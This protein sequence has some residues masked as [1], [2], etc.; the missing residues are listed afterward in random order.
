MVIVSFVRERTTNVL[1]LVFVFAGLKSLTPS[2]LAMC[3]ILI[4]KV[5]L[6]TLRS[7]RSHMNQ[8]SY[9]VILPYKKKPL[10]SQFFAEAKIS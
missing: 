1:A 2:N 7:A 9:R 5:N 3:M 6:C 10:G 8:S 4:R